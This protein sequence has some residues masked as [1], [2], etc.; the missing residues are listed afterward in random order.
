M[1]GD[2]FEC[3][4]G[5]FLF[6]CGVVCG[7]AD[8]LGIL[9]SLLLLLQSLICLLHRLVDLIDPIECAVTVLGSLKLFGVE[10]VL[11]CCHF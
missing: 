5:L 9:S 11:T 1:L 7:L 8:R 4:G 3:F 6:L 2:R 10:D